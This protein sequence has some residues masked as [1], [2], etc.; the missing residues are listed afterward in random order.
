MW[1]IVVV[2]VGAYLGTVEAGY[3]RVGDRR[4]LVG[5]LQPNPVTSACEED[6]GSQ[7]NPGET[8]SK[9]DLSTIQPL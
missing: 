8:T 4:V 3:W 6:I 5:D 7:A 2:G 1:A 9:S